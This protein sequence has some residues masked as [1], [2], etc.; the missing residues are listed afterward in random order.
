MIR[1][2]FMILKSWICAMAFLLTSNCGSPPSGCPHCSDDLQLPSIL[3]EN[4][5]FRTL[6]MKWSALNGAP[7]IDDPSLVCEDSFGEVLLNRHLRAG[8]CNWTQCKI[9][10]GTVFGSTA[11]Y[12]L[13]DD[14]DLSV[15]AP[16]DVVV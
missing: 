10:L 15:G 6:E 9:L 3:P 1:N 14:P 5:P 11:N 2:T 4:V 8:T 7:T 13:F 12:G 16:G